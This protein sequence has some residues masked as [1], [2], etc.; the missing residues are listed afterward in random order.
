MGEGNEKSYQS[1]D[2]RMSINKQASPTTANAYTAKSTASFTKMKQT[3]EQQSEGS[4]SED[5]SF[6][7]SGQLDT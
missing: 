6:V 3:V 5:F 2:Y 7:G 1:V 4:V